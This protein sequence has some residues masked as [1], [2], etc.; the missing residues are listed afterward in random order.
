MFELLKNNKKKLKTFFL[1][2]IVL[3]MI[4]L[5]LI[6]I[7]SQ[8]MYPV[9]GGDSGFYLSIIREMN[10][11]SKYFTEI[12]SPYTPLAISILGIPTFL[13]GIEGKLGAFSVN[14]IFMVG[15]SALLYKILRLLKNDK[16]FGVL[17]SI[18][19][20]FLSLCYEGHYT[21]L[22][23]ITV[24]FLIYSFYYFIKHRNDSEKKYFLFYS[25]L[26]LSLGFLSKQYAVFLL[27]PFYYHLI[28]I[29]PVRKF[30]KIIIF[31]IS[32]VIPI[33]LL[34]VIFYS[35][36]RVETYIDYLLGNS[37]DVD[38][39]ISSATGLGN[40]KPFVISIH[41]LLYLLRTN[42]YLFL[43]PLYFFFKNKNRTKENVFFFLTMLSSFSVLY[44]AEYDHYFHFIFPFVII[45]IGYLKNTSSLRRQRFFMVPICL[46]IL[47]LLKTVHN[48]APD[49]LI[50]IHKDQINLGKEIQKYIPEESQVFLS[51]LSPAYYHL[52]NWRSISLKKNS[53][54]FP[55]YFYPNTLISTM[56]ENAFLVL[57][58]KYTNKYN[59]FN[60]LFDTISEVKFNRKKIL[61]LKK[62]NE[63]R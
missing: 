41:K 39:Q 59:E 46:S 13:F 21:V 61:I 63:G 14:I 11:G 47:F 12:A 31:S 42:S 17:F 37:L 48:Q 52:N 30:S 55:D 40:Y 54:L 49:V 6:I 23:P 27:I 24:F 16:I 26:L 28:F 56:K 22:E 33:T 15:S 51:G 53:F 45:L 3:S 32:L 60:K 36:L 25:G 62:R 20:F 43:I 9:S 58:E 8:F 4:I 1:I 29:D 18:L 57:T 44:F 10:Q 35:E 2:G 50:N 7:V 5:S 19:F 34:Y 38:I